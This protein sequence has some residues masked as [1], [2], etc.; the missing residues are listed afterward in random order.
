M[1]AP[2]LSVGENEVIVFNQPEDGQT[3][4]ANPTAAFVAGPVLKAVGD[5]IGDIKWLVENTGS[6]ADIVPGDA[7]ATQWQTLAHNVSQVVIFLRDKALPAARD[8]AKIARIFEGNR[9]ANP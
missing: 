7:A 3:Q 8:F 4:P 1:P 2:L 9:A 5:F 6:L